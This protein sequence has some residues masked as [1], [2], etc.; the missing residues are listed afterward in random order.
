RIF[1]VGVVN[2][3]MHVRFDVASLADLRAYHGAQLESGQTRDELARR[4]C[5][6]VCESIK[7]S[8][9]RGAPPSEPEAYT[10]FCLTDLGGE[11]NAYTWFGQKRC[12]IAG[13]LSEVEPSTLSDLQIDE[14][15]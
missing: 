12:D 7:D 10:V 6:E 15:V 14:S 11:T 2:V 4:L 1:E 9:V 13:L 8:M 3:A 5:N